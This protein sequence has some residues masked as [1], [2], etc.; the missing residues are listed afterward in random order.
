M[1]ICHNVDKDIFISIN[2][3][4]SNIRCFISIVSITQGDAYLLHRKITTE[5]VLAA[6]RKYENSID[7]TFKEEVRL[8]ISLT[9]AV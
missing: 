8:I 3:N 6:S 5:T 1:P 9:T 7:C 4:R 2:S